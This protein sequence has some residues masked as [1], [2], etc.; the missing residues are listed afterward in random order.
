ML[1]TRL[2]STIAINYSLIQIY[3]LLPLV[4]LLQI[5]K[6]LFQLLVT[7]EVNTKHMSKWISSVDVSTFE[8]N[9]LN[10]EHI[11]VIGDYKKSKPLFSLWVG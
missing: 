4:W 1:S 7:F 9:T 10:Y 5:D 2:A 3:L 11:S 8:A 6:Y